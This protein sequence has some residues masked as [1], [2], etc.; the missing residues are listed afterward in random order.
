MSSD[1]EQNKRKHL[2]QIGEYFNVPYDIL[3]LLKITWFNYSGSHRITKF[4]NQMHDI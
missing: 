1:L 4:T 2:V 3:R